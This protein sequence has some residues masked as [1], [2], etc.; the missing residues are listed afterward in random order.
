M[1]FFS[2]S[3]PTYILNLLKFFYFFKDHF[4]IK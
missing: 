2:S 4:I 1:Y 3:L